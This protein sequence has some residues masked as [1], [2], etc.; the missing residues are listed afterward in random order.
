MGLFG[1]KQSKTDE[2]IECE[3]I[4]RRMRESRLED[5]R[6]KKEKALFNEMKK[7]AYEARRILSDGDDK[8]AYKML[9]KLSKAGSPDAMKELGLLLLDGS[10]NIPVDRKEGLKQLELAAGKGNTPA[11]LILGKAY[12]GDRDPGAVKWFNMALDAKEMYAAVWLGQLYKEGFGVE[13]DEKKSYQMNLMAARSGVSNGMCSLAWD[14]AQG[15][16]AEKNLGK[17]LGWCECAAADG[18]EDGISAV[19]TLKKAGVTESEPDFADAGLNDKVWFGRYWQGKDKSCGKTPLLWEVIRED[20]GKMLLISEKSVDIWPRPDCTGN[21]TFC[22]LQKWLRTEFLNDAFNKTEQGMLLKMPYNV[23]GYPNDV[24]FLPDST[25]LMDSGY[26][27]KRNLYYENGLYASDKHLKVTE[28]IKNYHGLHAAIRDMPW[29][30]L[31]SNDDYLEEDDEEKDWY[32]AS[33]DNEFR[34][35]RPAIYVNIEGGKDR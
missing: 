8:K 21:W 15:F 3:E 16:G 24:I 2:E 25:L 30:V 4:G 17:A 26:V 28:F 32:T 5:E 23:S 35:V 20:K 18:Y 12:Y 33:R 29:W 14:Y 10:K 7:E 22:S 27:N 31:P 9:R 1:K 34:G 11:M 19:D 6:E 13:K